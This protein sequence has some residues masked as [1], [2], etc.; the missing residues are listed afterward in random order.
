MFQAWNKIV[1]NLTDFELKKGIHSFVNP[2]SM[3]LLK[4]NETIVN[5]IDFWHVDGISLV[6]KMNSFLVKPIRRFSFDDTSLAPIVFEF[7]KKNQLK[8]GII[9][10]EEVFIHNAIRNIENKYKIV[11]DYFRNGY[12]QNENEKH[13]CYERIIFLKLDLIIC[14]MGT[15]H[16]EEFLIGLRNAGWDGYG[17]TCG[18]YL[19]QVAQKEN[20]YPYIFDKLNIRWLYRIIDEPRLMKRY[21]YDYPLFFLNFNRFIKENNLIKKSSS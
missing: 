1:G 16:Q 12:F 14:G 20:Y 9:G 5:N 10:T 11:V 4:N 18:G 15:P 21:G 19:H 8:I 7:A 17:F 6:N 2:Y 13:T 3:L